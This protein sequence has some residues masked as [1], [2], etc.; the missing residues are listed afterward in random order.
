MIETHYT[1]LHDKYQKLQQSLRDMKNVLVAFS[2]GVD[3]SL[4]VVA[5]QESGIPYL[6]VTATS[7]TMPTSDL[8]SV[9]HTVEKFKLNH[10]IIESG[11]LNDPNFT[12]NHEDRC[13]YCKTDLFK[14]LTDLAKAENFTHVL[15]GTTTDDLND[16]RPG[17]K[18]KDLFFVKS[19]LLMAGLNKNEIRLL[20]REKGVSTWDK[21]ASPCLSSRISFGEP[22]EQ[23][24]LR[25]VENAEQVL[26]KLGFQTLRVRKQGETARIELIEADMLT[27]MNPKIRKQ[28]ISELLELGFKFITLDLEGFQSGKLNRSIPIHAKPVQL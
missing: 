15:D 5:V 19:P 10:R 18:A 16:V 26:K 3:S 14:R 2:G 9:H 4:L 12:R 11:E 28:A 24:S 17:L 22:I 6:A 13:Y 21:P 20:S 7:P 1:S 8:E 23:E 25:M 27:L